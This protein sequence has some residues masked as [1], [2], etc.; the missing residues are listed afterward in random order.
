MR[1]PRPKRSILPCSEMIR[2]IHISNDRKRDAE[3][4][5]DAEPVVSTLRRILPSGEEPATVRLVKFTGEM[6]RCLRENYDTQELSAVLAAEDPDVDMEVTGRKLRRT[7]RLF[8]D[9]EY[10]IVY[11]VNLFQIVRNPDGTQRERR[12]LTKLS[13]NVNGRIPLR[14]TGRMYPRQEAV[15]RFVFTRNYQLRH[16]NG[17]TFDLLY[18]MA[19]ELAEA[20]AMVLIGAGGKGTEPILL[21]RGGQPYRGLLEGRIEGDKYCLILHLT[22]IELKAPADELPPQADLAKTE[23]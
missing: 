18:N 17:A 7:R 23:P 4:A 14:W 3:V 9:R 21:S 22:D 19:R 11:H 15:R 2:A 8:V 10:A 6:N 13:G 5:F 1:I 16:V 20:D 12:E